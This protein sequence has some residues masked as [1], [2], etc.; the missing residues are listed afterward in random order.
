MPNLPAAAAEMMPPTE[1]RKLYQNIASAIS[2]A[3]RTG[4]YQPGQRLPP[5]RELAEEFNVSRPTIRE[6]MIALDIM[7]L[8]EARQGSG[9]YVTHS[10]PAEQTDDLDIGAFELTEARRLFEGEAVALAA[11]TITDEEL[12]EL[13]AI[14]A[15][16]VDENER[17]VV[18][19]R[20]DRRFHVAI[21]KATRNSAIVLV[22]ETLW[23]LRYK[24]PLCRTM[25]ARARAV[26][27]RPLVDDHV[28]I[29]E[30]LKTRDPRTAR[31][32][33]HHHLGTVIENLLTATELEAVQRAQSEVAARRS[34][35]ARRT[36][37]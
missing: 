36:A 5:E 10:R 6:A 20:A 21:A 34:E 22:V 32:A 28:E 7:G 29:V 8:V 4:A 24:S 23:D 1:G 25:L 31:A 3:I 12:A 17:D 19:D 14:L 2:K 30:A 27:I 13:T 37:L 33:M 35:L 26:G 11:T 18:G 15:D 9:I 16:M